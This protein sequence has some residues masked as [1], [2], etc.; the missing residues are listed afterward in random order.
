MQMIKPRKTHTTRKFNMVFSYSEK[1][2]ENNSDMTLNFIVARNH[3]FVNKK[4]T[5]V[6]PVWG[7]MG[8]WNGAYLIEKIT[9]DT[10]G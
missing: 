10:H 4:I 6:Y 3:S 8:G 5:I 2:F 1:Y 7:D 9:T